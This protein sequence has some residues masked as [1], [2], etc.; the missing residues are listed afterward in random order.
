MNKVDCSK[1][2][3]KKSTFSTHDNQIDGA[4]ANVDIKYGELVEKG[5]MR[6]LSSNSDKSFNGMNN[7]YVFTWSDDIP[8]YTWAFASGCAAF[9]NTGLDEQTNTKM[10]RHFDE[11]RFDIYASRDILAGDELTHT[12]KSLQW[13]NVFAPLYNKLTE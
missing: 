8:N 11:D 7:P 9:Y 13:R 4:F 2:I 12:Y 1:V 10:I 6:R 5:I 3:V